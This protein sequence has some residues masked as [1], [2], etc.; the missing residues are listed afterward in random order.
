M[1]F[2][3]TKFPRSELVKLWSITNLKV[4]QNT[5]QCEALA[6]RVMNPALVLSIPVVLRKPITLGSP[7][8]RGKLD[9]TKNRE[10]G[11]GKGHGKV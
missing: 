3:F 5:T 10:G 1:L 11:M 4:R 7:E 8:R 2:H 6:S 9:L